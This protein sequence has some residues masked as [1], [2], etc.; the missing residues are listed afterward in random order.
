MVSESSSQP[1][2]TRYTSIQR[3]GEHEWDGSNLICSQKL[4]VCKIGMQTQ[5]LVFTSAA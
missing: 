2:D 4:S 3:Q 1:A 5:Y